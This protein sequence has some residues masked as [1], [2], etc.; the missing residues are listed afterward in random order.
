[1]CITFCKLIVI[2]LIISCKVWKL[3]NIYIYIN[4]YIGLAIKFLERIAKYD[5]RD[6]DKRK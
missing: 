4:K 5:K 3:M 6:W 1:M 2:L